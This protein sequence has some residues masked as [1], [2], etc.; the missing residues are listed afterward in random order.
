MSQSS[1]SLFPKKNSTP[2]SSSLTPR[3]FSKQQQQQKEPT[4]PSRI[5]KDG[6]FSYQTPNNNVNNSNKSLDE[7]IE[8]FS[9]PETSID[10]APSPIKNDY[11]KDPEYSPSLF[12]KYPSPTPVQNFDLDSNNIDHNNNNNLMT[13]KRKE[14]EIYDNLFDDDEEKPIVKSNSS[15]APSLIQSSTSSLN[16]Q[17]EQS[18]VQ[19]TFPS[20]PKRSSPF[21]KRLNVENFSTP[22]A[23]KLEKKSSSRRSLESLMDTST[24]DLEQYEQFNVDNIIIPIRE[25]TSKQL[26]SLRNDT[27][28]NLETPA[29]TKVEKRHQ[30]LFH[31]YLEEKGDLRNAMLLLNQFHMKQHKMNVLNFKLNSINLVANF[32]NAVT[33]Q[34][35]QLELH[36]SK[37]VVAN[38]NGKVEYLN[39]TVEG[40]NQEVEQHKSSL[41]SF[42]QK[43]YKTVEELQQNQLVQRMQLD[44]IMKL[45]SREGVTVDLLILFAMSYLVRKSRIFHRFLKF[46]FMFLPF[47]GIVI[48]ISKI[49]ATIGLMLL[50]RKAAIKVGVHAGATSVAYGLI[51]TLQFSFNTVKSIFQLLKIVPSLKPQNDDE[52]NK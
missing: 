1:S 14:E 33:S 48:I 8:Y 40:L 12:T 35:L 24:M 15:S 29:V 42:M 21:P 4:T 49:L 32:A 19:E 25:S 3:S 28:G 46:I 18:F 41:S 43:Y 22:N 31:H 38:L 51:Q 5:Q 13:S 44:D 23:S 2:S 30:E 20:T 52:K 6:G 16:R 7:E 39:D 26:S 37:K 10:M 9:S 36:K 11:R 45:K 47:N 34:K 27:N 17:T 50:S